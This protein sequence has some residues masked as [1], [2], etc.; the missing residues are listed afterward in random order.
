[1]PCARH[2]RA[3]R[4]GTCCSLACVAV[5]QH[6]D[7]L[8]PQEPIRWL[9]PACVASL[10]LSRPVSVGWALVISY[11]YIKTSFHFSFIVNGVLYIVV[12]APR[13]Q[14]ERGERELETQTPLAVY[15]RSRGGRSLTLSQHRAQGW[16]ITQISPSSGARGHT[17]TPRD[18]MQFC[19]RP[20]ARFTNMLRQRL[21]SPALNERAMASSP[22]LA[23]R[24]WLPARA[25]ARQRARRLVCTETRLHTQRT[26]HDISTHPRTCTHPSHA[27]CSCSMRM[28]FVAR[29]A[30]HAW[31]NRPDQRK[32]SVFAPVAR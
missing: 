27:Q 9:S 24:P 19:G 8:S 26:A 14:H 20:A 7:P 1:M 15:I 32:G 23:P 21:I 25:P 16:H 5:S 17:H 31:P 12:R 29:P 13:A 4:G 30:S 28:A 2:G 3:R 18:H 6:L 22:G 11:S 10:Q